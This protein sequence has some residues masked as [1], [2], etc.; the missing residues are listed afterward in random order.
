M[1]VRK[2]ATAQNKTEPAYSIKG[3]LNVNTLKTF[4]FS[5]LAEEAQRCRDEPDFGTREADSADR[6]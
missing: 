5:D 3:V 4:R 1:K 2:L 6:P